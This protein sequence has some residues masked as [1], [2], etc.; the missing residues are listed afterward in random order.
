[1]VSIKDIKVN[2]EGGC[3]SSHEEETKRLSLQEYNTGMP[4]IKYVTKCLDCVTGS[5]KNV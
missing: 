3:T 5:T 4:H 1:M 2:T